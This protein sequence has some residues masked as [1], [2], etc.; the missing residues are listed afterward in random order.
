MV[1]SLIIRLAIVAD[2]TSVHAVLK[3]DWLDFR[4]DRLS[5]QLFLALGL[6]AALLGRAVSV[7]FLRIKTM[8]LPGQDRGVLG[9]LRGEQAALLEIYVVEEH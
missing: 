2:V 4:S 9:L 3:T 1:Q 5:T 6:L 8:V 7:N